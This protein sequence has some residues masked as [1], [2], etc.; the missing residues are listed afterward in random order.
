ME[1]KYEMFICFYDNICGLHR[2]EQTDNQT[3]R[4]VKTRLMDLVR[5]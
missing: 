1:P 5:L 2:F 3:D 4:H